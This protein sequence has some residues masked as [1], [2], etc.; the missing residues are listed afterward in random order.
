MFELALRSE[1]F[2]ITSY[3]GWKELLFI[4]E[5]AGIMELAFQSCNV[6]LHDIYGATCMCKGKV[7][8]PLAVSHVTSATMLS[9]RVAILFR[10]LSSDGGS[11]LAVTSM[12]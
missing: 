7:S 5:A 1:T 8:R 2:K 9:E 12:G 11:H 3:R 10:G 4:G 6:I